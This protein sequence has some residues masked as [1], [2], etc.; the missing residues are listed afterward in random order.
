MYGKLLARMAALIPE[1]NKAIS[2]D[3]FTAKGDYNFTYFSLS[4]PANVKAKAKA[5]PAAIYRPNPMAQVSRLCDTHKV[6]NSG[7]KRPRR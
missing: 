4:K 6:I 7:H 3:Y 2:F 1:S 5:N